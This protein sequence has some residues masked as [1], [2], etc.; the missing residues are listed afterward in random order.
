MAPT[1]VPEEYRASWIELRDYYRQALDLTDEVGR[2]GD[3]STDQ[4]RRLAQLTSRYYL[5]HG[6]RLDNFLRSNC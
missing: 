4:R 3:L 6:S 5:L 1:T 2:G